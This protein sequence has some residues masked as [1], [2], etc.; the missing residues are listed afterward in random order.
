MTEFIDHLVIA[1]RNKH[2]DY[3]SLKQTIKK[4]EVKNQNILTVQS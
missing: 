2:L 1:L 3:G 4:N